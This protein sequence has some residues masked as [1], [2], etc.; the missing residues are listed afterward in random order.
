[1]PEEGTPIPAPYETEEAYAAPEPGVS[2]LRA[3]DDVKGLYED[4]A[5]D[6]RPQAAEKEDLAE[7]IGRT[8]E[9]WA[10][11]N[12]EIAEARESAG[13]EDSEA[14]EEEDEAEEPAHNV[15]S[16]P[17]PSRYE[18]PAPNGNPTYTPRFSP[19]SES[20]LTSR[21]LDPAA[22]LLGPSEVAV[23]DSGN[24]QAKI[25]YQSFAMA[26]SNPHQARP[27]IDVFV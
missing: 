3:Y 7:A 21:A 23:G 25:R 15:Q 8:R 10:E 6:P 26:L 11:V 22:P 4:Q 18:A 17:H 14:E 24:R 2:T 13:R 1:M 9:R 20:A 19:A 12:R 27:V 16:F 5:P